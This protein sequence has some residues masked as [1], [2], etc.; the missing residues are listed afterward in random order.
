MKSEIRRSLERP[1]REEV[2]AG[3]RAQPVRRLRRSEAPLI[4]AERD[5]R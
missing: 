4:R 3:L 1:T 2:L 5:W